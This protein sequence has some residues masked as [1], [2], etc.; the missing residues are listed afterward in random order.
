MPV[1]R[2]TP[3]MRRAAVLLLLCMTLSPAT[4]HAAPEA[5]MLETVVQGKHDCAA[6]FPDL[7]PRLDA[8]YAQFSAKNTKYIAPAL[9]HEIGKARGTPAL[10][11][12]T[13]AECEQYI[14]KLAGWPYDSFV[15]PA[16]EDEVY[17]VKLAALK[18]AA[19]GETNQLGVSLTQDRGKAVVRE[20]QA[21]TPAARAGILPGD[22]I[23][24]V[25]GQAVAG[26]LDLA[27]AV[28]LAPAGKPV[29]FDLLRAGKPLSLSFVLARRKP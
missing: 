4:G 2:S 28:I 1:Y 5:Q 9:W 20:V 10:E 18:I 13:R 6:L 3:L 11:K 19:A 7:V 26:Y 12:Y 16:V 22:T 14:A 23:V 8:A 27:T 25:G 21:D 15:D 17:F 24:A 29:R